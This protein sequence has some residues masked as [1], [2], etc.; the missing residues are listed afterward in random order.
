MESKTLR[1]LT[2]S[3][4]ESDEL[5]NRLMIDLFYTL[6]YDEV[7]L[8]TQTTG[9][10]IIARGSHK[11]KPWRMLA[12]CRALA[13]KTSIS[14]LAALANA[15]AKERS[16]AKE[17]N[18]S[19]AAYCVS[20]SGFTKIAL[21]D[22][23]KLGG[24]T[25]INLL[26]GEDVIRK[27]E[28]ANLLV[29]DEKAIKLVEQDLEAHGIYDVVAKRVELLVHDIGYV[30]AIYLGQQKHTHIAFVHA[31]GRPLAATLG[32]RLIVDD[33]KA[34]GVLYKMAYIIPHSAQPSWQPTAEALQTYRH[35]LGEECGSIQLDGLPTDSDLGP[36]KLELERL[37]VP[38]NVVFIRKPEESEI[39]FPDE[40]L[41]IG[42]LL[43]KAAH[44]AILASPGGG[45]STLLKRLAT[46]YAFPE[47]RTEIDDNLPDYDWLPLFLRCRELQDK[48]RLP[49]LTILEDIPTRVG[50][51]PAQSQV[52]RH[53]M[54][55]AL[56]E[57]R[58]LL[59]VDGLDE[60]SQEKDRINFANNLRTFLSVFPKTA[61]VVTSREAGFRLV[62]GT[63]A[64]VCLYTRLATFSEKDI[65]QLCVRWL[66]EVET[67]TPLIRQGALKLAEDIW[68]SER[69]RA[70]A[71]NPLLLTTLLIVKR[72]IGELP[73]N[74]AAL[75]GVA[76]Q[77]LVRTWNVEGYEP[78][79][80]Q[81]TLAQLSYV[82]C[83]M[84]EQ[85]IQQISYN[86]LLKL[87]NEAR[88]ELE[89]ELQFARV[90][91]AKFIERVESRSSLLMQTG[92]VVEDGE[93]QP[94][95]EFRHLTF[96][97]YS[98]ARGYAKEQHP[99]RN[100]ELPLVNLLAP[101]FADERWREVVP[102]AVV[103]ADRRDTEG[104]IKQLVSLSSFE[105]EERDDYKEIYIKL[106]LSCILDE[107]KLTSNTLTSAL[108]TLAPY[109]WRHTFS[110]ADGYKLKN[111]KVGALML[112]VVEQEFVSGKGQWEYYAVAYG[113]LVEKH[114]NYSDISQLNKFVEEVIN[115][116]AGQ[117]RVLRIRAAMEWMQFCFRNAR[118]VP[119]RPVANSIGEFD[120]TE[121][122]VWLTPEEVTGLYKG[123][124][125]MLSSDDWPSAFVAS[126]AL[127][128]AGLGLFYYH[129]PNKQAIEQ[130]AKLWRQAPTANTSEFIAWGLAD[131]PLLNR[132]AFTANSP[133]EE[134]N[135]FLKETF[136]PER[137]HYRDFTTIK[138][139]VIAAWYRRA[140]W[141]DEELISMVQEA[142]GFGN[143]RLLSRAIR[144]QKQAFTILESLGESGA[145][146]IRN[147]VEYLQH[148]SE[149]KKQKPRHHNAVIEGIS[150]S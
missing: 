119:P 127:G 52:F 92:R 10:W 9:R 81:E 63:I 89:A 16:L 142:Y 137:D 132:E 102:L 136:A 147:Q 32:H 62:A 143:D 2:R 56:Q 34:G 86:A 45:K 21:S 47:R 85:G 38:L 51:Q 108:R 12:E 69:I 125:N 146:A 129:S 31:D 25:G 78:L 19:L 13:N 27:L 20:L 83:A 35:W 76:V 73:R 28:G 30:K 123:L 72:W 43:T 100:E 29:G 90:S 121:P 96:Q 55:E 122:R 93:L 149:D 49:I 105:E 39:N 135:T 124:N 116:L 41:P 84:M 97:E 74:R 44:I 17:N 113:Y 75:Y 101:H 15:A 3:S 104:T 40:A 50:M 106:L 57:G 95:Y 66:I 68:E 71:V 144:D 133:D 139:V 36:R 7:R 91:P 67:D 22:E 80:E 134:W 53:L 11:S 82:A 59:L 23:E 114:P 94:V 8:N 24:L 37:F 1:F 54:Q 128:W 42:R 58:T 60:I 46:A 70:L 141:S 14:A 145:Q 64:S 65:Q 61:L 148:Y 103:M 6:G 79:D 48:I 110:E 107:V 130:L 138:A 88:V 99:R 117:D 5:F 126:W 150:P 18:E 131:S 26:D 109:W 111:S 33:R 140:P 98:A 120:I 77:V 118:K 115:C 112:S 4:S 87:L